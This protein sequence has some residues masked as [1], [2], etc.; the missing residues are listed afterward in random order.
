LSVIVAEQPVKANAIGGERI[1][2][3]VAIN[4]DPFVLAR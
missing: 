2:S 1:E 4:I 3:A